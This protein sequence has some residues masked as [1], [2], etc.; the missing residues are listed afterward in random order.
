[1]TRATSSSPRRCSAACNRS[2]IRYRDAD[3]PAGVMRL[4]DVTGGSLLLLTLDGQLAIVAA[5][6]IGNPGAPRDA[7][8]F[9]PIV[10]SLRVI[11][12]R[13]LAEI[14]ARLQL[15]DLVVV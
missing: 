2:P 3:L 9:T 14:G 11:S 4:N 13:A 12:P 15:K 8:V 7:M 10:M 6:R 5:M 1:M